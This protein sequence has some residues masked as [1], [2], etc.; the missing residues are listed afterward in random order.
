MAVSARTRR[1]R[2]TTGLR[3]V[4]GAVAAASRSTDIALRLPVL[5]RW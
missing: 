1:G 4:G 2:S 5:D 3:V